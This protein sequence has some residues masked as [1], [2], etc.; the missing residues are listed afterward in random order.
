VTYS[1]A[2]VLRSTGDV[3]TPLINSLIALG[4]GTALS[5]G[6]IFGRLGLPALGANGAALGAA[7][8]RVIECLLL[9]GQVYV[10][11]LVPAA[12]LRTLLGFSRAFAFQVLGRALPVAFNEVL[13][14]LGITS[15]NIIYARIGTEAIAAVNIISSIESVAFVVFLGLSDACAILV[16]NRIGAGEG[17]KAF[18]YAARSLALVVGSAV[19][20]GGLLLVAANQLLSLYKVSPVVVSNARAILWVVAAFLWLRA[21]NLILFIGIFRAG[22]DTRFGFVLDSASIWLIGVPLAA[23]GAFV[24]RLPIPVVYSL[25]MA[26]EAVKC[27]IALLRFRS[28]RWVHDLVHGM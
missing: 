17:R 21:S 8:A 14:S 4:L 2:A 13:W 1:F 6:L 16:G 5:Y 23:V 11:R 25:I 19:I 27:G 9:V 10:R 15:Y 7:T 12:S 28:R 3:R 22:G 20:V 18:G 24:W 26:E